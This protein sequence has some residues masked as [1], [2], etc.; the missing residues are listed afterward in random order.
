[1]SD[2]EDSI[3][4]KDPLFQM[5]TKISNQN[6]NIK[7]QNDEIN[8]N[9]KD[10]KTDL[11]KQNGKINDII[12]QVSVLENE[13][14]NLKKKL[15]AAEQKIRKNNLV[16]YG[17]GEEENA[18]ITSIITKIFSEKL[19]IQITSFDIN[20]IYRVGTKSEDK[21]RPVILELVRYIKKQ[22]IFAQ[23]PK[24]KGTGIS[25]AHD[26]TPEEREEK[27]I[28]YTHYKDARAKNYLAKIKKNILYINGDAYTYEDLKDKELGDIIQDQE[29]SN[30]AVAVYE[31]NSAP[32]TPDINTVSNIFR[33]KQNEIKQNKNTSE[34]ELHVEKI[35]PNIDTGKT[36]THISNQESSKGKENKENKETP[37]AKKITRSTKPLEKTSPPPKRQKN[38]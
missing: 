19:D 14:L 36:G 1:M 11:L 24:L 26:L 23:V 22:E 37:T 16:I 12:K 34:S 38:K 6:D 21:R 2:N 4:N 32:A 33:L 10:I 25:L 18:D 8:A 9:I 30:N 29:N 17:V 3:N 7:K 31:T 13:N 20:N 35:K 15:L 28:L 27:K 5:L